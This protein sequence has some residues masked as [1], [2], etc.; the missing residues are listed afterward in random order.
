MSQESKKVTERR[1]LLERDDWRCGIHME[2]CG[3]KID[4][5]SPSV[6][7]VDHIIPRTVFKKL[8]TNDYNGYNRASWNKQLMHRSCNE[9]RGA[10]YDRSWPDFKCQCHFLYLEGDNAYVGAYDKNARGN[11]WALHLYLEN[12]VMYY[13]SQ[14]EKMSFTMIPETWSQDH[15]QVVGWMRGDKATSNRGH[16]FGHVFASGV[17][18]WNARFIA[19]IR[20]LHHLVEKIGTRM[21]QGEIFEVVTGAHW[22]ESF[23]LLETL[24]GP[25]AKLALQIPL[26][27][28]LSSATHIVWG[29][30]LGEGKALWLAFPQP[31]ENIPLNSKLLVRWAGGT[32]PATNPTDTVVSVPR[33]FSHYEGFRN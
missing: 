22:I 14:G 31:M 26:E 11:E 9:K 33:W 16:L 24:L 25:S 27:M 13:E 18:K 32:S 2:G 3:E 5:P 29:Y 30:Q 15:K 17:P 1:K 6:C 23:I 7:T 4:S 8:S 28:C 21:L 12:I 20:L 19:R 10:G